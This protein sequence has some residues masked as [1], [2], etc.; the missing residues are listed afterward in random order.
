[1][2]Q[3]FWN[4]LNCVEPRLQRILFVGI[5]ALILWAIWLY[6]NDAVFDGSSPTSFLHVIFMGTHWIRTWFCFLKESTKKQLRA[7]ASCWRSVCWS[8][9]PCMAG[10]LEEDWKPQ[11]FSFFL[12]LKPS[13]CYLSC[14]GRGQL[15]MYSCSNV[16]SHV[17]VFECLA[18]YTPQRYR[19]WV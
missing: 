8:S 11:S 2:S 4:W 18:V 13:C 15:L 10:T 7:I 16:E 19:G 6:R 5:V 3:M 12:F 1:M 9:S 17:L 14:N